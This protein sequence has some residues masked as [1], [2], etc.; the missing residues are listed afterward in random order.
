[1]G[2]VYIQ[3][4]F[5]QQTPK[6]LFSSLNSIPFEGEEN[7]IGIYHVEI[8]ND[9][10]T[11]IKNIN[12]VIIIEGSIIE[13]HILSVEPSIS[14]IEI[15]V[16]DRFSLEIPML[17]S[18]E[19]IGVSLLTTSIGELPMKPLISLRGE[20]VTGIESSDESEVSIIETFRNITTIVTFLG[21][22][23]SIGIRYYITKE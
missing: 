22:L 7:N 17:N 6:L 9:G 19:K 5:L 13:D 11:T 20:G 2:Y 4:T 12:C 1:M 16:E 14:Y 23:I 10:K 15:Q 18:K 8:L 21:V 3:S